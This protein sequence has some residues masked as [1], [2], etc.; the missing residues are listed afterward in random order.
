MLRNYNTGD[1]SIMGGM[2]QRKTIL[3][4][5]TIEQQLLLRKKIS[6]LFRKKISIF[7][8]NHILVSLWI[9]QIMFIGFMLL[10]HPYDKS[11]GD[12]QSF[13]FTFFQFYKKKT[14]HRLVS[15]L[16]L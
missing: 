11:L 10:S 2:E 16:K 12:A 8:D 15:D 9:D 7:S 4:L 1:K 14:V 3:F 5:A 6:I 13:N